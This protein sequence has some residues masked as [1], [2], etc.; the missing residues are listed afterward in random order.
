MNLGR[1]VFVLYMYVSKKVEKEKKK[2]VAR[3]DWNTC[4]T[5]FSCKFSS[6]VQRA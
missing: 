3:P 1:A 5:D 6:P 2:K 4:S